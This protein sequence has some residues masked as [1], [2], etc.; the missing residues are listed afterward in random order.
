MSELINL[1]L[2]NFH[3]FEPNLKPTGTEKAMLEKLIFYTV[4]GQTRKMLLDNA[5]GKVYGSQWCEFGTLIVCS[6]NKPLAIRGK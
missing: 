6:A 4:L 5:N 2:I 1:K 3:C